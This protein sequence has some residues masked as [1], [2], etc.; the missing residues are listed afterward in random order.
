MGAESVRRLILRR[1]VV[2]EQVLIRSL[3]AGESE[4]VGDLVAQVRADRQASAGRSRVLEAVCSAFRDE[5][6]VFLRRL[7]ANDGEAVDEVWNDTLQRA[8]YRI[9]S[10]DAARA[11]FRAWLFAQA[12]WAA[13]DHRRASARERA[14]P[15]AEA[16]ELPS[17]VELDDEPP[18]DP[19][20]VALRQA[21]LK[22]SEKELGCCS[23]A[24]CLPA[25]RPS[26]L[27][28]ASRTGCR[29]SR[30]AS[31]CNGRGSDCAGSFSR[32]SSVIPGNHFRR[33]IGSGRS[34]SSRNLPASIRLPTGWSVCSQRSAPRIRQTHSWRQRTKRR[35]RSGR[36]YAIR[37]FCG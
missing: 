6:V 29:S 12:K 17:F 18:A 16:R 19:D 30:F 28:M 15:M 10:F 32:R 1:R 4:F 34:S 27:G 9:D 11:S 2:E 3:R 37:S 33:L 35:L 22:L 24:T 20:V 5:I 31:M 13:L 23:C 8:Y 25:R 36:C 7:L 26:W 14:I 21:F